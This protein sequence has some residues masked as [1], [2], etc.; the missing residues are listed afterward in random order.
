MC[1]PDTWVDDHISEI[2]WIIILHFHL[3]RIKRPYPESQ[4]LHKY[5]TRLYFLSHWHNRLIQFLSP[6]Q[7][8]RQFVLVLIQRPT[9]QQHLEYL[10]QQFIPLF[11]IEHAVALGLLHQQTFPDLVAH[12]NTLEVLAHALLD[13]LVLYQTLLLEL[14]K[15]LQW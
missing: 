4:R 12:L 15:H 11:L 13:V 5:L 9:D 1:S 14:V 3:S 6:V 7:I 10:K 8:R 2:L